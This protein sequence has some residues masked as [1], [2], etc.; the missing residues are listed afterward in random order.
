MPF[1]AFAGWGTE[2]HQ[3]YLNLLKTDR[4]VK[5][6]KR[7]P[8]QEDSDLTVFDPLLQQHGYL[9]IKLADTQKYIDNDIH[10]LFQGERW[11][12]TFQDTPAALSHLQLAR[13]LASLWLTKGEL[14]N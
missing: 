4:F 8:K 12:D 7:K 9:D 2:W 5:A 14:L 13:R 3:D 6:L 10:P 1:S 11:D